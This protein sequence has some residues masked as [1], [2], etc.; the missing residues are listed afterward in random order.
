MSTTLSIDD[1]KTSVVP[2]TNDTYFI[3]VSNTGPSPVTGAS[4]SD[5]LPAGVTA[6]SWTFTGSTNGGSVTGPQNGSRA[7]ATPVNLPVNPRAPLSSTPAS[8]P[9]APPPPVHPRPQ[10]PPGG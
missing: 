10:S 3:V 4:V 5:P 1:V 7:L 9:H 6:A 2:G 8:N